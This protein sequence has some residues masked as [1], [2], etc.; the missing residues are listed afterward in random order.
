MS[1]HKHMERVHTPKRRGRVLLLWLGGIVVVV[2]GLM[3]VGALY[4]SVTEAADVRAY[5]PP[6]R[7]VDVGGYRL[8]INCSGTGSPTVVI[9]VGL[10]DWSMMWSWVQPAVAKKTRV[11]TYDR[12]GMGWSE[13]GPQPR[14]AHQFVKELHAL[15]HNASIRGPYV[16]V[17]HSLGGFTVRL[18]AHDYPAEVAGAVLIESMSPRQVAHLPTDIKAQPTSQSHAFS[19]LPALARVGLVRLVAQPLGLIPHLPPQTERAYVAL[20]VRPHYLQALMDEAQGIPESAAQADAVK[21]LG[22]VPLIVLS[23]GLGNSPSDKTW[24]VMQ[25]E[26]L[27]L[28]SHSQQLIA[29]KS[30]HNIEIDQPEAAVGAIMKMVE[31]LR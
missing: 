20:F 14:T 5:P 23:R 15:L 13:V 16:L 12:A 10:S 21:T 22:D 3:L 2:L 6:G 25:T 18:F 31:Q 24:Q 28:S 4:E 1:K 9:D 7:L 30:G 19:I 11:C 8:H 29:H 17:G 27:H 26:L